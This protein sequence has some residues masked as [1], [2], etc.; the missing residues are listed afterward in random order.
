LPSFFG[1]IKEDRWVELVNQEF[2]IRSLI[3]QNILKIP[4]ETEEC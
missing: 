2:I 1:S 3:N 4:Q